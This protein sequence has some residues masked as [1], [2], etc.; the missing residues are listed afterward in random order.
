MRCV[1]QRRCC[2]WGCGF[3]WCSGRKLVGL[4][5][6]D[7]V[8]VC[9]RRFMSLETPLWI[10][11]FAHRWI[12]FI[13]QKPKA[14]SGRTTMSASPLPSLGHRLEELWIPFVRSMGWTF[15]ITVGRCPFNNVFDLR[16]F[17]SVAMMVALGRDGLLMGLGSCSLPACSR[18]RR[19]LLCLPKVEAAEVGPCDDDDMRQMVC[20]DAGLAQ[21]KRFSPAMLVDRV[22]AAWSPARVPDCLASAGASCDACLR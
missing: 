22:G 19:A 12:Q 15:A 21:A 11:P 17:F 4:L 18:G 1:V 2:A 3:G 20:S 10:P 6:A 13:G 7:G 9:G 14:W 8:G 5:L 16:G